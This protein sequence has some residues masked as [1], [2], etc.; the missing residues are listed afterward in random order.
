M[1]NK[2]Y[3]DVHNPMMICSKTIHRSQYTP[4]ISQYS[5]YHSRPAGGIMPAFQDK[6]KD[7]IVHGMEGGMLILKIKLKKIIIK[8]N[9]NRRYFAMKF[10]KDLHKSMA[11]H[12]EYLEETMAEYV[13]FHDRV[14]C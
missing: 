10:L 7:K 9:I 4:K 6:C 12:V 11:R 3:T 2:I 14:R 5:P 8:P 1:L 13:G